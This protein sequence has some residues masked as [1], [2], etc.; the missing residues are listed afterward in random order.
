MK[1]FHFYPE[2]EVACKYSKL[3]FRTQKLEI[4]VEYEKSF[5][6]KT[7]ELVLDMAEPNQKRE[8]GKPY[9]PVLFYKPMKTLEK[10]FFRKTRIVEQGYKNYHMFWC[11]SL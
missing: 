5:N 7:G 8:N 6:M 11:N 2:T 3:L 4:F 9:I 1:R 10:K